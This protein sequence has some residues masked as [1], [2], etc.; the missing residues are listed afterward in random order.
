MPVG[1]ILLVDDELLLR[2][3]LS[4]DLEV[5]GFEVETAENGQI[6]LELLGKKTFDLVITDLVMEGLDG[7][8]V[9]KGAKKIDPGIAVIILTGY[10]DLKSA[11]DALRLGADDYLLKPCD[12][13]ELVLRISRCLQ[14]Q[15]FRK[16]IKVYENILPICSVC[17]KIRDDTGK[18]HG[19]GD[20]LTLEE[21]LYRKSGVPATH[22]YCPVCTRKNQGLSE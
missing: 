8:Q 19:Q 11:I 18:K 5:E 10:G 13:N 15:E 16:K 4:A 12:M 2:K 7:I 3:T 1:N 22:G 20:W 14:Q 9:L 6:G 21:Y 17:K